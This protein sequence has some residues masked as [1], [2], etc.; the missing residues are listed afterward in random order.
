MLVF[1]FMGKPTPSCEDG[2][3]NQ[4]E[5]Q[6]DCGGPCKPCPI[7]V[8]LQ[9]LEVGKIE[10]VNQ[11]NHYLVVAEVKNTNQNYGVASFRYRF[12]DREEDRAS[13]AWQIG[14]I[15]PG[16]SKHLIGYRVASS[17]DSP[18]FKLEFDR[19]SFQWKKFSN[20]ALPKL[21]INNTKYE[22]LGGGNP[23]FSQARGIL[24]NG[25]DADFELITVKVFLRDS[26]GGL[27]GAGQQSMNTLQSGTRREFVINFSQRFSTEVGLMKQEVETN[28]FDSENYI[29]IHGRPEVWDYR[30]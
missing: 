29:R 11:G 12:Y 22:V 2:I 7:K 25:S 10:F 19:D 18:D 16:G 21:E 26:N 20:Y 23:F 27:I 6:I 4:N 28:I 13:Q 14:F 5:E 1:Y 24:V 17:S 15:L 3:R 8:K 30:E 9:E